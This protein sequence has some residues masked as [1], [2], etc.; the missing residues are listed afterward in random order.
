MC[1]QFNG[2]PDAILALVVA[3]IDNFVRGNS[4]SPS[5]AIRH[6]K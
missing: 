5:A 6:E 2:L 1:W 3:N 4:K